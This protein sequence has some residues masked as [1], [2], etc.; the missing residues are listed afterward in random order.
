M[1]GSRMPSMFK[2]GPLRIMMRM[3]GVLWEGRRDYGRGNASLCQFVIASEAKRRSNPE[4]FRGSGLDYFASL[5]MTR[6]D[7][8]RDRILHLAQRKTRLDRRNSVEPRQLGL[9]E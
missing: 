1:C 2:L 5:A 7:R 4:S 8:Q 6:L 3:R 9:Q